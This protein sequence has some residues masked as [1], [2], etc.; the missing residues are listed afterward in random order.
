MGYPDF[1]SAVD[2]VG[3]LETL[4]VD[5]MRLLYRVENTGEDFY[6]LLADRIGND[7]AAILLRKNA[8]EERGHAERVRRA[9][10]IKLGQPFE[11]SPEDFERWPVPLPDRIDAALFPVIVQAEMDGDAGYQRWADSEPDPEVAKLL[12]LN[13]REETGHG[14]RVK[15]VMAILAR[16]AAT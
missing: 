7:E 12:R 4:D 14:E 8:R 5:G 9:I 10:G 3:K 1:F 16:A 2:A 6:E 11:P 13:G 15:Q